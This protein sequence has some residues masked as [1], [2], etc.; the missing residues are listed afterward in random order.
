MADKPKH[1]FIVNPAG[2]IHE[3]TYELAKE[4]LG[5]VGYR[6]ATPAE[7]KKLNSRRGNVAAGNQRFDKPIC[8]PFVATPEPVEVTGIDDEPE[9][10]ADDEK[11]P[12]APPAK[13]GAK[14]K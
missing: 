9:T 13:T 11:E 8:E 3:V 12:E 1:Y 5:K 6:N 4:L 14:G 10:P 2:A 7:V